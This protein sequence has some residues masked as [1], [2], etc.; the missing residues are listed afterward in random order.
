MRTSV[1]RFIQIVI[2][3]FCS[4]FCFINILKYS[5][6]IEHFNFHRLF[7]YFHFYLSISEH[8]ILY[9]ITSSYF[10]Y[11]LYVL[12][13]FCIISSFLHSSS[14]LFTLLPSSSLLFSSL[15]FTPLLFSSLHSS[16]LL[17]SSLHSSPLFFS[18]LFP[19]SLCFSS[20]MI[21]FHLRG[22]DSNKYIASSRGVKTHI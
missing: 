20:L 1:L 19:S 8:I 7:F 4:L 2:D 14:L 6:E 16:S 21:P 13:D 17:F 22:G 18:S 3:L 12:F 15:F 11:S 5:Y 9:H 10:S